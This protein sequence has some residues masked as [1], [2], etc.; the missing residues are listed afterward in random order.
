MSGIEGVK[1][2]LQE[3][4]E[5]KCSRGCQCDE[6]DINKYNQFSNEWSVFSKCA[7]APGIKSEF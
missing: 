3:K 4:T 1:W 6:T 7:G 5:K 2:Y